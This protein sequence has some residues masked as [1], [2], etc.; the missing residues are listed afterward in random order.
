LDC[1][2][3]YIGIRGCTNTTSISGIYINDFLP[4]V[5]W[6]QI[7]QIADS[8]QLSFVQVWEDIQNRS[9]ARFR[10]DVNSSL[11]NRFVNNGLASG[12]LLKQIFQSN[13]LG[14]IIDAITTFAPV[15]ESRGIKIH[16]SNFGSNLQSIHIQSLNL[17]TNAIYAVAI[18]VKDLDTNLT[19]DTF[20]VTSVIG[21]NLVNVGKNYSS[22]NLSITYNSTLI[23]SVSLDI[24]NV[25]GY[26]ASCDCV[27][28]NMDSCNAYVTGIKGANQTS[29]SFGLSAIFSVKCT[30]D[31]LVCNNKSNFL[32]SWAYLLGAELMTERIYS[33]RI[34]RWTTIDK[35]RAT[36]LR[37]EFEARYMGGVVSEV[38]FAGELT[39]AVYGLYLNQNDCCIEC[40]SPIMYK[41][42]SL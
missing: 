38:K 28:Y 24:N 1:L 3:D 11:Q 21:W 8:D 15:N 35:A 26:D 27:C 14:Q 23:T 31:N 16:L 42:V 10:N 34:N 39:N 12:Y 20:N 36:E 13:N 32:S 29:D 41:N 37:K 6:K 30:Y 5:E 4:G 19:L 40:D 22:K 25:N 2:K 18:V 9:I 33:S 7:D 17:Y